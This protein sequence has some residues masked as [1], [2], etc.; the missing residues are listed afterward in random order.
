MDLSELTPHLFETKEFGHQ[1]RDGYDIDEVET[2]LEE[3]GTALA[4]LLVRHR[5]LEE[6]CTLAESR[7]DEAERRTA[8][9]EARAAEAANR[10]E[11]AIAARPAVPLAPG[12]AAMTEAE[13][14]EQA[15]STLVLARRTADAAIAEARSEADIILAR[16]HDDAEAALAQARVAAEAELAEARSRLMGVVASLEQRRDHLAA[17]VEQLGNRVG[18]YRRQLQETSEA[19]RDIA[20]DPDALGERPAIAIPEEARGTTS[21]P[22]GDAAPEPA[23][24]GAPSGEPSAASGTSPAAVEAQVVHELPTEA[25]EAIAPAR[26]PGDAADGPARAAADPAQQGA[27]GEGS[28]S[29]L[30]ESGAID[31]EGAGAADPGGPGPVAEPVTGQG[32]RYLRELDEAV[33]EPDN[34][35]DEAMAAFFEGG[36]ETS[37]PRFG[38]RR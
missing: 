7:L 17:V 11:A 10:A 33:N 3:T 26:E 1:K 8:D 19:L 23:A 16:A 30:A 6:R 5:Q 34:G 21:D 14:I 37:R 35:D 27:W 32:D 9:A 2:F 25:H 20:E 29:A 22:G 15:A 36:E 24:S 13:E 38:W 28:W 12:G 4:Q 18:T 31:A